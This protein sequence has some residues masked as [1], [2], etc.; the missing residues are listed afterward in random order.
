[1][2]MRSFERLYRFGLHL[3]PRS[4]REDYGDEV[5]KDFVRLAREAGHEGRWKGALFALRGL[6]ELLR[7]ALREH[8]RG[9]S[10]DA[11]QQDLRVAG[12]HFF[13]K[14]GFSVVVVVTLALG[15]GANSAI[16]ALVYDALL[17]PLPFPAAERLVLLLETNLARGSDGNDVTPANFEDWRALSRSFDQMGAVIETSANWTGGGE[18][19]RLSVARVSQ[20]FFSV[21]GVSTQLGRVFVAE[22]DRD[23]AAPVALLSHGLWASRFG[24]RDDVVGRTIRLDDRPH[25]IGGVLPLFFR[26]PNCEV[27][28]FVPCA[29]DAEERRR[30]ALEA[31]TISTLS[32]PALGGEPRGSS[33]REGRD[34]GGV[35]GAISRVE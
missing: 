26:F 35:A 5:A 23:G 34:S 28:L 8:A 6:F 11:L 13:G 3:C 7:T 21:L 20:D 2:L 18:L 14:P 15:I 9:L 17:R 1:M 33:R 12:R 32:P 24:G 29:M 27:E 4:F 30:G 10:G 25:E 16:F 22:E 19:E 31:R